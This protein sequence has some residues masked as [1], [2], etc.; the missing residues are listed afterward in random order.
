MKKIAQLFLLILL[1]TLTACKKHDAQ[2]LLS[3]PDNSF[4]VAMPGSSKQQPIPNPDAFKGGAL[5][6]TDHLVD[7]Q[8]FIAG[9]LDLKDAPSNHMSDNLDRFRD[10]MVKGSGGQNLSEATITLDGNTGR[11]LRFQHPSGRTLHLHLFMVGMRLYVAQV[12]SEAG[13]ND[14]TP[15][16]KAFFDSFHVNG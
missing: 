10:N 15:A 5:Y 8:V 4:T 14:D 12:V 1:V 11:D 13:V 7:K 6:A 16:A 9:Y 3:P 2:T